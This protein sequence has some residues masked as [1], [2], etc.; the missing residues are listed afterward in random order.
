MAAWV[1][2]VTWVP[3]VVPVTVPV[4]V[5]VPVL[6]PVVVWVP[7]V[8]VWDVGLGAA[9]AEL[10]GSGLTTGAPVTGSSGGSLPAHAFTA[11]RMLRGSLPKS[12]VRR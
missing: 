12:P 3:V 2:V 1:P 7:E 4:V 11:R 9:G 6:V 5:W 8:V 10:P